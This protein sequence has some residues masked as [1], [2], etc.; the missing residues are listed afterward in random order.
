MRFLT[1]RNLSFGAYVLSASALFG[2]VTIGYDVQRADG[3]LDTGLLWVWVLAG[4]IGSLLGVA[5][6]Q[7][8]QDRALRMRIYLSDLAV[9]AVA[10]VLTAVLPPN[11]GLL[12]GLSL[13]A[14]FGIYY[15]WYQKRFAGPLSG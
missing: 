4:F 2:F 7:R 11:I 10:L 13:L 3:S 1:F 14:V 5:K 15:W 8:V 9:I 6:N 12:K